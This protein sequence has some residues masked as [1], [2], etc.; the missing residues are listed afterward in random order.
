MPT[1]IFNLQAVSDAASISQSAQNASSASLVMGPLTVDQNLTNAASNKQQTYQEDSFWPRPDL[2]LSKWDRLCPY[3]LLVVQAVPDTINGGKKTGKT[4]YKP[5]KDWQFT[6]PLPPESMQV[7]TPF[8]IQ[9]T[10]TLN[11]IVEEHN[12]APLKHISFRGTTG[13]LPLRASGGTREGTGAIG[14]L[15]S[16]FGGTVNTIK[17]SINSLNKAAQALTNSAPVAYNVYQTAS[18]DVDTGDKNL[19]KTSGF[20]QIA[21]LGLSNVLCS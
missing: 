7:S 19:I 1:P 17:S 13:F 8:A 9:T 11:G 3:Q 4:N 12:A 21:L 2:D 15:E 14:Q 10:V 5:Y 18:F 6:L 20:N 16:I